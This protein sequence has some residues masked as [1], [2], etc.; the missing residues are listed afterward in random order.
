MVK[1]I[2]SSR[3]KHLS[4]IKE[5]FLGKGPYADDIKK[6]FARTKYLCNSLGKLVYYEGEYDYKQHKQAYER[7]KMWMPSIVERS[8]GIEMHSPCAD[9]R[10][11]VWL[12]ASALRAEI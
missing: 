2:P 10:S 4:A 11:A 12:Q 5:G 9:N 1:H 7:A 6:S 8:A 3:N